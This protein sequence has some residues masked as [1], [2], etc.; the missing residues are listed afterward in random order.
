MCMHLKRKEVHILDNMLLGSEDAS[1]R[2]GGVVDFLVHFHTNSVFL[3][4]LVCG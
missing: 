3:F 1:T 4:D 2:Y